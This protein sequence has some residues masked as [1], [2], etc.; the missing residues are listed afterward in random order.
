MLKT[1]R[2]PHIS[3]AVPSK[4]IKVFQTIS[5]DTHCASYNKSTLI[6]SCVRTSKNAG[7]RHL[8]KH[9]Q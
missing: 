7:C 3:L 9:N 4:Q 2:R 8:L 5:Q 6:V 1:M